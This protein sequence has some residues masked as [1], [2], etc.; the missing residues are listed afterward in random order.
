M[1]IVALIASYKRDMIL[2]DCLKCIMPQVNDVVL[3]GSSPWVSPETVIVDDFSDRNIEK[4]IAR[5][6]GL[7]YVDHRNSP[8]GQKW[9]AGLNKCR[10]LKPDAVLICGSDDLL[11]NRWVAEGIRCDEYLLTGQSWWEV[12][13]CKTNELVHV[14]YLSRPDPI[15]AGRIIKKELL[16]KLDWQIFPTEG[17]IGCDYYSYN[18]M[19]KYTEYGLNP[20]NI[21]SVKG[22]WNMLDSWEQIIGSDKLV[23]NWHKDTDVWLSKHFPDIDFE[24]YR[25]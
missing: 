19:L 25:S 18:R 13:N 22:N 5:E 16:D 21:L 23:Y 12:Y 9:Q 1:K 15:G 10:E 11:S 24:K 17:G 6:L 4:H 20:E 8:L 2:R 3:V 7:I 14:A